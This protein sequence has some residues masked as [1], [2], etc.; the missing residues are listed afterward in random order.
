MNTPATSAAPQPLPLPPHARASL[1]LAARRADAA[2]AAF[3]HCSVADRCRL[4][5]LISFHIDAAREAVAASARAELNA[6]APVV[7]MEHEG[8]LQQLRAF[9]AVLRRSHWLGAAIE[10]APP[11]QRVQNIALG[12]VAVLGAGHACAAPVYAAAAADVIAALAAGCPVVVRSSATHPRTCELLAGAIAAAVQAAG[13][14]EG[15]YGLVADHAGSAAALVTH[16]DIKAATYAGL[17]AEGM[18]LMRRSLDRSEPVPVLLDIASSN[19]VFI[20]PHALNARA[21]HLGQQLLKQFSPCTAHGMFKPGIVVAIEGDGYID[22]RE[23]IIDGVLAMPPVALPCAG[24]QH[25]HAQSVARLLR[26]RNV[27]LLAES[28]AAAAGGPA[29]E[30]RAVF[31]EAEASSLLTTPTLAERHPG[32]SALLLRCACPEELLAVAALLG[33]QLVAGMQMADGDTALAARLMPQLE[34]MARHVNVNS[35]TSMPIYNGATAAQAIARFLRPVFYLDVP[36][37]LLPAALQ[38]GNPLQL[39]RQVD[40]EMR[41]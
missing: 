10:T 15:V 39:W 31:V 29:S 1:D 25:G 23:T 41:H 3:R 7:A 12:P 38:D 26:E 18:E 19:P 24:A 34:R 14:P 33:R 8:V 13:L 11:E 20:L 17:R 6:D 35:F 30:A 37:S 40:G 2:A 21:E 36:S 22:L 5:E 28:G 27:D 16:P 9:A 4:L 32:P